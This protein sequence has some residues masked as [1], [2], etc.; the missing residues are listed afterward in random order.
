MAEEEYQPRSEAAHQGT[1]E[2]IIWWYRLLC[3]QCW[4]HPKTEQDAVPV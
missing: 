3:L 2:T 4:S 1:L